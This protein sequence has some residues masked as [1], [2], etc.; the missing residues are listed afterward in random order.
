[1]TPGFLMDCFIRRRD[2][3]DMMHGIRRGE[4]NWEATSA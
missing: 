1:M 4:T 3:D 2:Y